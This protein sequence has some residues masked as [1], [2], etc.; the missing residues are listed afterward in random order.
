[1]HSWLSESA[2]CLRRLARRPGLTAAMVLCLAIGIG[3]NAAVFSVAN[4]T[5][6]RTVPGVRQ[7]S[8]VVTAA[9]RS[10]EIEGIPGARFRRPISFSQ[11]RE[12]RQHT[13]GLDYLAGF[14]TLPLHVLSGDRSQRLSGQ[15]VSTD[16]F[17][18]LGLK[19]AQG[20]FFS[21]DEETS[22]A[23]V[24]VLSQ[25]LS[26]R[27][28]PGTA[29]TK[30]ETLDIQGVACTVVGVAPRGF[31]GVWLDEPIDLWLPIG[32]Y[33]ELERSAPTGALTDPDHGWLFWFV[34][35]L[36]EG[37][38]LAH[39]QADLDQL[40]TSLS[41][42]PG[43]D[44]FALDL[45]TG[46][47][48]RAGKRREV[49]LLLALLA[50]AAVLVLAVACANVSGLA[51]AAAL[52]RRREVGIRVALGANRGRLMR[53][54]VIEG[55]LVGVLAGFLGLLFA[56]VANKVME[57]MALGRLL[58]EAQ[59]LS[60]N[61][62]L[63]LFTAALSVLAGCLTGL[64]PALRVSRT[65]P[66]ELLQH[67]PE[68]WRKLF[69]PVRD[70]LLI[71]QVAISLTILIG[72]GLLVRSFRN[73]QAIDLGFHP[74]GITNFRLDLGRE[75]YSEAE[76]RAFLET[77]LEQVQALPDV[78]GASL[79]SGV[80]LGATAASGQMSMVE[81]QDSQAAGRDPLWATSYDV[82]PDYFQVLGVPM[83][84]GPGLRELDR[85]GSTPAIVVNEALAKAL[86]QNRNPVGETLDVGDT[87]WQVVGVCANVRRSRVDQASGPHFYKPI[88]QS[89]S[90]VVSLHVKSDNTNSIVDQ[91]R[92]VVRGLDR[93]LPVYEVN[94]YDKEVAFAT[95]Q[96]RLTTALIG[97]LSLLALTLT[98]TGIFATIA[99][100]VHRRTF[101]FGVRLAVGASRSHVRN[102]ALRHALALTGI[103][104]TLGLALSLASSGAIKSRLY[105]VEAV[106]P[107]TYLAAI[108]LFAAVATVAAFLPARRAT[109]IEPMVILT[110]VSR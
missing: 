65:D 37:T 15:L 75:G 3:A 79:A 34:G 13:E 22:G 88:L 100:S 38:N 43:E 104:L 82:S 8:R 94:S 71:A 1:M 76:G 46:V 18:A 39:V 32:G 59:E 4:A 69:P 33:E 50:G 61:A 41:A 84:E 93:A 95:A 28:F 77:L 103:G 26:Q 110:E 35:R 11:L 57:G 21:P 74:E 91:V 7:P 47:G 53:L 55:L 67:R 27:L 40:T 92:F 90:P 58:P 36:A 81:T 5:L 20:R 73:L 17:E 24:V 12:L 56:I 42:E 105:G 68:S 108:L 10:M 87:T 97:M 29:D 45:A 30:G 23:R 48:I 66:L 19:P 86:W 60:T 96:P 6:L 52:S 80:A 89:Y 98:L 64:L 101:E 44:P 109:K 2:Y 70:L 106:D 51:L 49:R 107:A 78:R 83:L 9:T 102:L 31:A 25:S 62:R 16:Y 85:K 14:H 54:M 99:E 63:L 72:G